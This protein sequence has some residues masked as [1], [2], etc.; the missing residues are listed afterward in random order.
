MQF[1][2]GPTNLHKFNVHFRRMHTVAITWKDAPEN[3]YPIAGSI[4]TVKCEVTANPA[5]TVD[6]L[7]NGDPVSTHNSIKCTCIMQPLFVGFVVALHHI[8]RDLALSIGD[9]Q[10]PTPYKQTNCQTDCSAADMYLTLPNLSFKQIKSGGRYV[11]ETRGLLI[12]NVDESDDG[13]YTCRAAVIQTGELVERNIRVEVQIKPV[14]SHL[15]ERLE[16]IEEQQFSVMCNATGKPVPEFTWIKD[17]TQQN[18][19][20]ADRFLVNPQTGQMSITHVTKDDYGNY[21]CVAKNAAGHDEAKMM[22]DVLVRPRIYEFINVTVTED[23]EG[24]ITCKATGRPAPE[25]TFR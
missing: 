25:I 4:Y 3:Q 13:I 9:M 10:L 8:H 20:L 19:A 22:L 12:R 15:P 16:A 23:K 21:T 5:P 11:V 7:R 24:S 6:W 2:I 18:V 1:I 14:V 17:S